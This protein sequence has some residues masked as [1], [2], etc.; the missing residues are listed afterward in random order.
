MA[1]TL[2]N[3]PDGEIEC[4]RTRR[5]KPPSN[6]HDFIHIVAIGEPRPN[7]DSAHVNIDRDVAPVHDRYW[8]VEVARQNL[9]R[10]RGLLLPNTYER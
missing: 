10:H 6:G 5:I 1:P 3:S 8:D 7:E 9:N 2:A 4:A